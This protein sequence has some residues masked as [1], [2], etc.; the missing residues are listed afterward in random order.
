MQLTIMPHYCSA[1]VLLNCY[2]QSKKEKP[3]IFNKRRDKFTLRVGAGLT[4]QDITFDSLDSIIGKNPLN[5]SLQT[6]KMKSA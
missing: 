3:T 5:L 2:D 4:I 1:T 6:M